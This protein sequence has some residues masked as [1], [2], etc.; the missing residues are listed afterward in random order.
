MTPPERIIVGA[1]MVMV[2]ML[3]IL[4][5]QLVANVQVAVSK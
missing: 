3:L 1:F 2:L 4:I 5:I